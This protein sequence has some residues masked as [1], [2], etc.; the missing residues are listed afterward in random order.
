MKP[1]YRPGKAITGGKAQREVIAK[2]KPFT[3]EQMQHIKKEKVA[4]T[5]GSK[6]GKK[7][8]R[9]NWD[10]DYEQGIEYDKKSI[11]SRDP[12]S[13]TINGERRW[14]KRNP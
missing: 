5:L 3:Q 4:G 14:P 2:A 6:A 10:I 13:N 8:K 12:E 11:P 9:A 1:R 7:G